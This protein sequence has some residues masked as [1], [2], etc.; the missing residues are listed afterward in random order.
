[1]SQTHPLE[2]ILG[3]PTP[4][5]SKLFSTLRAEKIDVTGLEMDHICYRV[6]TLERYQE[7]CHVLKKH[8]ELL[9]EKEIAGRPISTFKLEN[10]FVY[11]ERK[12]YCLELPAPK[13]S[14]PYIEGFEHAEFV[15]SVDFT[16]FKQ[17]YPHLCFKE[18]RMKSVNPELTLSFGD[19]A[20]KFHQNSLEYVITVLEKEE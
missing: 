3:D 6:E 15:I 14:S 19:Y 16:T 11:G 13:E 2:K 18:S 17:T 5:L 12:I 9:S 10:P 20:V 1:M 7:L 4:F 8:G